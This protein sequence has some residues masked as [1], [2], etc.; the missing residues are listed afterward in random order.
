M[1]RSS[2]IIESLLK[3]FYLQ[4]VSDAVIFCNEVSYQ[5]FRLQEIFLLGNV[6][7]EGKLR[8]AQLPRK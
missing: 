1:I 3:T 6:D 7:S 5:H 2:Y 8:S 4:Y